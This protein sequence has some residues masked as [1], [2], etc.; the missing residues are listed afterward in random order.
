MS[1]AKVCKRTLAGLNYSCFVCSLSLSSSVTCQLIFHGGEAPVRVCRLRLLLVQTSAAFVCENLCRVGVL[2]KSLRD[3]LAA[4][5]S[6]YVCW[7]LWLPGSAECITKEPIS[8]SDK[9]QIFLSF[10]HPPAANSSEIQ[11]R[12]AWQELPPADAFINVCISS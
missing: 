12:T 2:R 3:L 5:L 1:W 8:S 9:N 11:S 10:Q 4:L 7:C 6:T